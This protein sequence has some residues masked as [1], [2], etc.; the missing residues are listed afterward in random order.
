MFLFPFDCREV[1]SSSGRFYS[2]MDRRRLVCGN[3][4][5][6]RVRMRFESN[7]LSAPF[8]TGKKVLSKHLVHESSSETKVL[9]RGKRASL[10]K[11]STQLKQ[12]CTCV[13]E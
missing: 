6:K 13:G 12:V 2:T 4:Q 11:S 10:F 3:V 5:V 1:R 8:G 9:S 7:G